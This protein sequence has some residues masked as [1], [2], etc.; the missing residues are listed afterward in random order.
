VSQLE[1]H[2]QIAPNQHDK[3]LSRNRAAGPAGSGSLST[4]AT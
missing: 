2:Q 3:G 1:L 4:S